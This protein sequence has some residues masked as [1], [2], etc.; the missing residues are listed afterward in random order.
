MHFDMGRIVTS[1]SLEPDIYEAIKELD[2]FKLS[3]WVNKQLRVYFGS[4]NREL[5]DLAARKR[6]LQQNIEEIQIDILQLS[7][8]MDRIQTEQNSERDEFMNNIGNLLIREGLGWND[9]FQRYKARF[10]EIEND[11]WETL[12]ASYG[13]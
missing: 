13:Y 5:Q 3:T 12:K 9:V 1:V 6:M 2:D 7:N 8:R 4:D 10:G 11:E